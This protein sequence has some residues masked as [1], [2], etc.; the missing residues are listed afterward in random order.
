MNTATSRLSRYKL[1]GLILL[2]S[3]PVLLAYGLYFWA[4]PKWQPQGRT[5]HGQL[6][7]PARPLPVLALHS[8]DG[9]R[10]ESPAEKRWTLLMIGSS[11]CNEAC[12]TAL[13][14][15]RQVRTALGKNTSRTR[16]LYVA[17]DRVGLEDL[18]A[19]IKR[20]HPDLALAVAEGAE[21]YQVDRFFTADGRHPLG[22]P[23]DIYLLDPH[24][25]W[26]MYYTAEQPPQGLLKDL[27]KL[28]RL[29]NIG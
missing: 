14:N 5:H 6:I 3:A 16:R 4:P 12:A 17:T 18:Q 26:L 24:D 27:K 13:Y 2:F 25:N 10:Y 15:S 21:V 23:N 20:E 8:V 28:L 1:I 9:Q 11:R 19:L 7:N 22:T 29:S